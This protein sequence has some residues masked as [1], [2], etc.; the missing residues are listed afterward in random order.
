MSARLGN[1]I[2]SWLSGEKSNLEKLKREDVFSLDN[3]PWAHFFVPVFNLSIARSVNRY[4]S[5]VAIGSDFCHVGISPTFT[6]STPVIGSL[7]ASI[8]G[9]CP[10]N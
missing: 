6:V 9:I 4:C 5:Y 2:L 8:V 10:R 1:L 3:L 7:H